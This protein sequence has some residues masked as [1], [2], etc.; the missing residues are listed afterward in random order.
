[1]SKIKQ[2]ATL[3]DMAASTIG[4]RLHRLTEAPEG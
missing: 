1:M 4:D 2:S 3:Q